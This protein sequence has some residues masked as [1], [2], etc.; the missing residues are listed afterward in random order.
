MQEQS[1]YLCLLDCSSIQNYVFGSNKLRSNVGA[2]YVVTLIYDDWIPETLSEMFNENNGQIK[3]RFELWEHEKHVSTLQL[4]KNHALNWETG[5]V[6]GG[7]A[8]LLF[9]TEKLVREFIARW[10]RKLMIRA[11]GIRPAVAWIATTW[12]NLNEDLVRLFKQLERNKNTFVAETTLLRHGIT[13][14][15]RMSGLSSEIFH[16]FPDGITRPISSVSKTKLNYHLDANEVLAEKFKSV[17]KNK[18]TKYDFG[19]ELDKLGQ[20]QNVENHIAIVH[21]DGNNMGKHFK[22]CTSLIAKRHLS[23]EVKRITIKAMEETLNRLIENLEVLEKKEGL[24]LSGDI[25]P[26][27]PIILNGDDVT[28]ISD[29]RLGLFLAETYIKAFATKKLQVPEKIPNLAKHFSACGGIAIIRTKYPFYRGYML[30]EALCSEAKKK[31]R[32]DETSWI[33][34]HISYRGISGSLGDIRQQYMTENTSLLWRPWKIT[35]DEEMFSFR[36]LKNAIHEFR[37]G[38]HPWPKSKLQELAVRLEQDKYKPDL[39]REYLDYVRVRGLKLPSIAQA[40]DAATKGWQGNQT[41]YY[42]IIEAMEYYPDSLLEING[43]KLP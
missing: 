33:D 24:K 4:K 5:Y 25:L 40:D 28:F 21:I 26:V 39:T 3:K 1:V 27:R 14:E 13:A 41:P 23:I 35:D 2:S 42:D 17:L 9:H 6:G 16:S 29:S 19:S 20:S 22:S 18:N 15:D 34:F 43:E 11:P 36:Q 31:G 10:S 12:Q 30:A 37:H 7:N 38:E 8:L 32:E